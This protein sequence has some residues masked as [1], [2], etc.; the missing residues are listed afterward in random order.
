MA[1]GDIGAAVINSLAIAGVTFDSPKLA[2]NPE[3]ENLWAL[4]IHG[5]STGKATLYTVNVASDG[6]VTLL[7]SDIDFSTASF[8]EFSDICWHGDGCVAI[9]GPQPGSGP[10]LWTFL[11]DTDTGVISTM[12]GPYN[13][14]VSTINYAE[15]LSY[16]EGG[17]VIAFGN[18][19]LGL[20]IVSIQVSQTTGV[21][22]E[23]NVDTGNPDVNFPNDMILRKGL[24]ETYVICARDT[25]DNDVKAYSFQCGENG[26]ITTNDIEKVG[27]AGAGNGWVG[28]VHMGE[29]NFVAAY[30]DSDNSNYLTLRVFHVDNTGAITSPYTSDEQV[31]FNGTVNCNVS[32]ERLA[33]D[34]ILVCYTDASGDDVKLVTYKI[35]VGTPTVFT[36]IDTLTVSEN[37]C[38]WLHAVVADELSNMLVLAYEDNV[39][40]GGFVSTVQVENELGGNGNGVTDEEIV[41]ST[42]LYALGL[43]LAI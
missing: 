5:T 6:T 41:G 2:Q 4:L 13:F 31:V 17:V 40:G 38:Y 29:G 10:G 14:Y 18:G 16:G 36:Q 19:S 21:I 33:N 26:G 32:L 9:V 28:L 8:N 22:I 39:T 34:H 27:D 23:A 37:Q 30:E 11:V 1:T 24:D 43:N 25:G 42:K 15:I 20:G 7:D 35:E 3:N 12:D